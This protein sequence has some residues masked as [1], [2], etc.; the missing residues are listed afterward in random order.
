MFFFI[1]FVHL[2]ICITNVFQRTRIHE[3]ENWFLR[4]K[5]LAP[6]DASVYKHFGRYIFYKI[7]FVI[8]IIIIYHL[9]KKIVKT[10]V[11]N[12]LIYKYLW[13]VKPCFYRSFPTRTRT[14]LWSRLTA[15]RSRRAWTRWLRPDGYSSHRSQASGRVA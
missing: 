14:V 13:P 4:A 11:N 6:S 15:G 1:A 9:L 5:K 2:V 8:I 7:H 3:A 10:V 12:I